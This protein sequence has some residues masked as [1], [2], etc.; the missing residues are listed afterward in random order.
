M[1]FCPTTSRLQ[2]FLSAYQKYIRLCTT[3]HLASEVLSNNDIFEK[4]LLEHQQND[5]EGIPHCR[6]DTIA[7]FRN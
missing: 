7:L 2:C 4:D 5:N 3:S 6:Y 1:R